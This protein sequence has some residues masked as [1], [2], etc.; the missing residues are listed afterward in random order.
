MTI[1]LGAYFLVLSHPFPFTAEATPT[2][3]DY[4]S[5]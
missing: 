1:S 4:L 3:V 2:L 5:L